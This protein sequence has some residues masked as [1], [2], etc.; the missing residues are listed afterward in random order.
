MSKNF[1]LALGK[2]DVSNGLMS[3][4]LYRPLADTLTFGLYSRIAGSSESAS[5][6]G[7]MA[8]MPQ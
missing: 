6:L 3:T 4:L 5:P 8:T 7:N 1:A 2:T